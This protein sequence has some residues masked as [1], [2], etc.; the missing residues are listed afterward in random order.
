MIECLIK[1]LLDTGLYYLLSD[2]FSDFSKHRLAPD[3]SLIVVVKDCSV[4]MPPTITIS[5][6]TELLVCLTLLS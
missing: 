6:K 1:F 4:G 5:C 2:P 3:E